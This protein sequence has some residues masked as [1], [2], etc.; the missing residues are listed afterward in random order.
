[1]FQRLVFIIALIGANP[2]FAQT[3]TFR[4]ATYNLLHYGQLQANRYTLKNA[5]LQPVLAEIKPTVICFNEIDTMMH[6]AFFDTINT[7]MPYAMQYGSSHNTTG[8]DIL[9]A[10][11]WKS[12]KFKYLHDTIICNYLRDIVAYDL[13]YD[14]PLLGISHDTVKVKVITAHLKSSDGIPNRVIRDTETRRVMRYLDQLTDTTNFIMLGDFNLYKSSEQSY[15]N[16]TATTNTLARLN[17]P[18]NMPGNWD[19]TASFA[20]IHTQSPRLL[21]LSDGGA[22]GGLDSRFDFILM[23]DAIIHG[24]KGL[25]YIP[26]TYKPFGNDGH[27]F[28]KALTDTPAHPTLPA[29]IIQALYNCSDHLPV[30]ADISISPKEHPVTPNA[31][32]RVSTDLKERVRFSNPFCNTIQYRVSAGSDRYRYKLISAQGSVLQQGLLDADATSLSVSQ[33]LATGYYFIVVSDLRGNTGVWKLAQ[34]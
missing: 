13:Y 29:S 5:A 30:Y 26:N 22:S 34:F 17:D 1:M 8:T 14:D 3:D 23:S 10:L 28:N 31:V 24:W 18:L 21:Q 15:Q 27:H 12:G 16:L 33:S 9:D 4:I 25:K 19:G 6:G 11:F 7:V 20:A 32:A 2:L